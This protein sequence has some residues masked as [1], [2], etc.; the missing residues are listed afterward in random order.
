MIKSLYGMVPG[1]LPAT[2]DYVG[3]YSYPCNASVNVSLTFGGVVRP[4]SFPRYRLTEQ[5][6][7]I[8][9]DDFNLGPF[10]KTNNISTCLGAFFDLTL[11]SNSKINWVVCLQA[12]VGC[13]DDATQIGAAFLKN[14]YSVFRAAPPSVGFAL[15]SPSIL[16]NSTIPP[17]PFNATLPNGGTTYGNGSSN[18]PNGF[19]GPSGA[20]S[21]RPTT[22]MANTAVVTAIQAGQTPSI[23]I[24][25]GPGPLPATAVGTAVGWTGMVLGLA[26]WAAVGLL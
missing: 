14:V 3:Y 19:F 16:S 13:A 6:Y 12:P 17:V 20:T 18:L 11:S 1:A 4:C 9:S 5:T 10:G 25:P 15:L 24:G 23:G 8:T 26:G 21:Q 7:N 2:G 22:V